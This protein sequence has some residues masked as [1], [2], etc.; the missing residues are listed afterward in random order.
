MTQ[1]IKDVPKFALICNFGTTF[2]S[3][4]HS[5]KNNLQNISTHPRILK[6]LLQNLSFYSEAFADGELEIFG[7]EAVGFDCKA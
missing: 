6:V 5:Q 2:L 1:L 3:L 4:S 7:S